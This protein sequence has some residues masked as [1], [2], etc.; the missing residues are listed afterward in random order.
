MSRRSKMDSHTGMEIGTGYSLGAQLDLARGLDSP[1][2]GLLHM[3]AY[4]FS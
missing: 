4:A 2:G 3:V 1:P